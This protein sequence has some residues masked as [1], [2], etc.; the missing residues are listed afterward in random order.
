MADI[1]DF[2]SLNLGHD[3]VK[4]AQIKGGSQGVKLSALASQAAINGILD[5]DSIEGVE[6]LSKEVLKLV[7]D[8]NISTKNFVLSVPETLVFSRLITLP[9]M[10]DEEVSD[11]IQYALK[12]LVPVPLENVNISFLEIDDKKV[13]ETEYTNWYVVAAPKQLITKFQSLSEKTGL[14]L[15]AIETESLAITRMIHYNHS[16]E[17][18]GDAMIIDIGAE[19]SN[20]ILSRSGVVIFSQNIGTG[21][22]ALTKVIAAD[23]GLDPNQADKYKLTYGLDF[24]VN[25]GKIAKSMEPLIQIMI[26]EISRTVTYYNEKIGGK[27]ISNVYLTGGGGM[28]K[29]LDSYIQQKLNITTKVANPLAKVQVDESMANNIQKYNINS[30]NVAIGMALKG[31]V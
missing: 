4:T 28:L 2:F 27:G 15:F 25:E 11:A 14:N 9:K 1:P 21:A 17:I 12:P 31:L 19:S 8:N 22:D 24:Q 5:N 7:K 16:D 20:V 6:T 29:N 10:K 18:Q 13:N 30:F 23:F 26:S 3:T